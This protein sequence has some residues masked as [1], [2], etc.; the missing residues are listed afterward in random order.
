VRRK[1]RPSEKYSYF[2]NKKAYL[3]IR[4]DQSVRRGTEEPAVLFAAFSIMQ[5]RLKRQLFRE[6]NQMLTFPRIVPD[7]SR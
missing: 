1:S 4:Q 3:S 7:S 6:I 5:D 2:I